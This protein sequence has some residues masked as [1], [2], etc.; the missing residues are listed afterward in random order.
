VKPFNFLLTAFVAPLGHPAG[1][2]PTRFHL[3]A[4]YEADPR[5]WPRMRLTELYSARAYRITTEAPLYATEAVRIKSYRDVLGDY[6]THPE[7]KSAGSDGTLCTRRTSGLLQRL[8]VV[9]SAIT[10]VGK[11]SNKLE[12]VQAGL[13]HDPDEVYTEYRDPAE[14]P[15]WEAVV[16]VLQTIPRK[17]LIEQTG[18]SRS[19]LK[20]VCNRRCMPHR[21]NREALIRAIR[22]YSRSAIART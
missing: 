2:D 11:E 21:R 12:E 16:R 7:T 5:K 9:P 1:V 13:V 6:R 17:L 14:N 3:V 18:L 8:W 4:P 19:T 22:A 15:E 10:H 20:A